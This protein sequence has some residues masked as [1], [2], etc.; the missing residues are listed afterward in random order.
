MISFSETEMKYLFI[1]IIFRTFIPSRSE[2][3]L[4]QHSNSF[5]PT[6]RCPRM[7]DAKDEVFCCEQESKM[8][9]CCNNASISIHKNHTSNSATASTEKFVLN[10]SIFNYFNKTWI[11]LKVG[12]QITSSIY[13]VI[14]L[15]ML[16][17][18]LIPRCHR[19]RQRGFPITISLIWS[20]SDED[21]NQGHVCKNHPIRKTKFR[22]TKRRWWQIWI[23]LIFIK[24]LNFS[25]SAF[26]TKI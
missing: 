22:S 15:V 10:S 11:R 19:W 8:L 26:L 21:L 2:L 25:L 20:N 13:L 24:F 17:A 12:V 14:I 5:H 4:P 23:F 1:I 7:S 3:C 18:D 9:F 6:F 16:L